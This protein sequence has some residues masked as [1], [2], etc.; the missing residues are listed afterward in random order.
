MSTVLMLLVAAAILYAASFYVESRER[1]ACGPN[2]CYCR[3]TCS[4]LVGVS[5]EEWAAGVRPPEDVQ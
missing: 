1:P 3:D 4:W 5:P 2:G